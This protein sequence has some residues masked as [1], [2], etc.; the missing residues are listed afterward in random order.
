MVIDL[1]GKS[2][3][4]IL[5]LSQQE[6]LFLLDL[7]HYL[8]NKRKNGVRGDLLLGKN[9]ALL[10]EKTS[11]RT[12]CSF[13][14]GVIEEG[15]YPSYIDV[16]SSQF[17]KKE[18]VED[19]ARVLSKFY[20]AICFRGFSQKT[21]TELA[22]YS[23][24]P[25]YNALTDDEH[26][27]QIMADLMSIQEALPH[28]QLSEIKIVFVGDTR[29]N[30]AYSWMYAC[31]KLGMHF[32]AYGPNLLHP[33]EHKVQLAK[34][35]AKQSGA[36]IEISD[37][38]SCLKNAD[39]IYTDVW[40]SMGEEDKLQERVSLL[41]NY[42]V[43]MD[44]LLQTNNPNIL[45]MH[46]LPAFHDKQTEYASL[47]FEKYGLNISE[48]TDEVFRSKHSIVFQ[49]AEN[50]LHTI[51]AIVVATLNKMTSSKINLKEYYE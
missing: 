8:K 10:F 5:D 34:E 36:K 41:K 2:F 15:G 20:H 4:S 39:I 33:Q 30:V 47:A 18:S 11:T 14:L 6:I 29:N 31:A 50:R 49:E 22:K 38:I 12:R 1:Y 28:K 7:S 35:Y 46:D 23:Q 45:F 17:G 13:E 24:L 32:V 43:T 27:T 9:V 26:P 21:V 40:V 25:V 44:M 19:T 3:L 42:Q 37:D 16:A 48:V 51:K